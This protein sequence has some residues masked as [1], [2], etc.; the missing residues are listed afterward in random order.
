MMAVEHINPNLIRTYSDGR[1]HLFVGLCEK[2]GLPQLFNQHMTK[3]T[4]RPMDLPPGIEAMILMAPMVEEGYKPLYQLHDYYHTKDLEGIFHHPV[5]EE[6]IKDDRFGYFLDAFYEAGCRQIFS[7]ICTNTLVTYGIQV[8]NINYDT[9]SFVMWGEYKTVEGKTGAISIDFG[10]SKARR[11]D[12]KQF[13]MAIGTAGGTIVDAKVL[14][15]NHSDKTFNKEN[16]ADTQKVL[17]RLGID[18]NTFHSIA[19]SAFFAKETLDNAKEAKMKWITRIPD[20]VK[21]AKA[22]IEKGIS[23][24]GKTVLYRNA[25]HKDVK[26]VVEESS[27]TY[28]GHALNCAVVYSTALESVKRKSIEKKV[29]KEKDQLDRAMKDL[30]KRSFSCKEDAQQEL[31]ALQQD[32]KKWKSAFHTT[33]LSLTT[34]EKNLQGRQP[35]DPTQKRTRTVYHIEM[36]RVRNEDQIEAHIQKECVFVLASNNP[37]LSAEAILLEYKTQSGVEKRFQQLKDP[38]FVNSLYLE[39]PERIEALAYLI[40][41]TMMMLS[42]MEQ[43]VRK[44]LTEEN[45][46]VL[47]TGKKINAQPT[48]LMILRLFYNIVIQ[49]YV[50]EGKRIRFLFNPLNDSQAKVIRYL[51][52]PESVFAWNSE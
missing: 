18:K 16:I 15:G 33:T 36:I 41:L 32:K 27:V 1:S 42:V 39:K 19:D 25:H 46:T 13:K 6:H 4:G 24:N 22:L 7:E 43:V 31:E 50:R 12:K 47:A 52:I 44:G 9:T 28:E 38:H 11:S 10:H 5:Q 23:E 49:T 8:K 48:Q 30:Q 34:V 37:D 20:N 26:Y 3:T 17:E 51:G 21:V 35:L 2:V 14:S 29:E 45:E 40:L